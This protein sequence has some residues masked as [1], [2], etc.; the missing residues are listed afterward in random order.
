MKRPIS[1][2]EKRSI[3]PQ[4]SN[5]TSLRLRG[6]H[7]WTQ[8][9]RLTKQ[10]IGTFGGAFCSPLTGMLLLQVHWDPIPAAEEAFEES[11]TEAMG[12]IHC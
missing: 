4:H 1:A 7:S 9:G 8:V 12:V 11:A 3:T 2:C 5:R 10:I 6:R